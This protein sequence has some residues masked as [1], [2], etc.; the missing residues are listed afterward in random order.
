[1]MRGVPVACGAVSALPE[2]AGDAALLFDP[3]SVDAIAA[4]IGHLLQD[5]AL[6]SRLVQRGYIRAAGFT[7][8]RTAQGTVASYERALGSSS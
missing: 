5:A 6:R 4:A 1:M 2:V 7:W 8:E 3:L